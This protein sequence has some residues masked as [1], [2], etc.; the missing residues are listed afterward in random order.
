MQLPS[1]RWLM[2][3]LGGIY[4]FLLGLVFF[5]LGVADFSVADDVSNP[6]KMSVTGGAIALF[7]GF[8]LP[9]LP[10]IQNRHENQLQ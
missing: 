10:L 3:L 6:S 7:V 1:L 9:T 4:L 5:F 8:A 2:T